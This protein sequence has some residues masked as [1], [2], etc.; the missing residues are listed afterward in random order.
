METKD[1]VLGKFSPEEKKILESVTE[2]ATKSVEC[3]I[4]SGVEKAMNL[5][6]S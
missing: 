3:M 6:N 4:K 5:Y 2:S 1:Y